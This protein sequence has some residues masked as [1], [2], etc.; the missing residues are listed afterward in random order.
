MT[1]FSVSVRNLSMRY[2][3]THALT[4]AT[5][6]LEAGG[7][8]GLLGRNGSGKTTLLSALA[9]LRP[10]ASGE[11][12]IEG[13]DPFENERVM[14]GVC[15]VREAGDVSPDIKVRANLDYF[16]RT[17]P[18]WDADYAQSLVDLFDLD[19][20]KAPRQLSRGQQSALGAVVGLASR[21]PLTMFDEVHLGMDAPT[22]YA[23][24]DTLLADVIEHPRTIVI[25]SHLISEVEK[26]FGGV[27]I[28]DR[29]TVLLAEDAERVRARGVTIT[30]D[31]EAVDAVT[32][33]L[34]VL[35]T[36]ELGRVREAT[37][38]GDLDADTLNAARAADLTVGGVGLQDLFVHLTRKESS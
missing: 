22:R 16:A 23:F 15:L 4:G 38:Y 24:Y 37:V 6:D 5:F 10:P 30:G 19:R 36:R 13:E 21:A 35:A 8:Y 14:A 27:V 18:T 31:R 9:S 20:G 26:L 25:S 12:L 32:T 29:G 33:S 7:I 2:G 3:R 1:G 11:V 17:W 28:L 34:T